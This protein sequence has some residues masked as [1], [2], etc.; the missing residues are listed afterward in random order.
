MVDTGSDLLILP[1]HIIKRNN[2]NNLVLYAANDTRIKTFGSKRVKLDLGLRRNLEW[3]FC[4]S[5]VPRPIIGADLI[6]HFGLIVDLKEHKLIDSV[7]KSN[8]RGDVA[9][10]SITNISLIDKNTRYSDILHEYLSL[11][12]NGTPTIVKTRDVLHRIETHGLPVFQRARRLSQKNIVLQKKYIE[13]WSRPVFVDR[14]IVPGL[15]PCS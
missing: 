2:P 10:S 9:Y 3:N 4:V 7:T 12:S 5:D 14:Q 6:A 1:V 11:F 13:N 8:C 15:H